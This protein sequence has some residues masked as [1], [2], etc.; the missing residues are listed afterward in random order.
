MREHTVVFVG[1]FF[2]IGVASLSSSG[3]DKKQ[4][5]EISNKEEN[6]KQYAVTELQKCSNVPLVINT[7][8]FTRATEKAWRTLTSTDDVLLTVEHGCSQCEEDRCDQTVG[9][10][11]SPDENAESVLDAL[12][13]DGVTH[14]AG[15]VAGLRRIKDAI[16]VAR[17]VMDYTKHTLLVGDLATSF[18]VE[19]G[20]RQEQLYSE[21]SMVR[22]MQ[23]RQNNCQPNFRTNVEPDPEES[24]GPYKPRQFFRGNPV[25]LQELSFQI[26]FYF[27]FPQ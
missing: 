15:S 27:F 1:L 25:C 11:G 24:C 26:Y 13:M 16:S 8:S 3:T 9:Y 12:I 19:M 20:F 10:G 21:E 6:T 23:W 18:A 5:D 22:W 7:W 2:L 17:S 14:R 4:T